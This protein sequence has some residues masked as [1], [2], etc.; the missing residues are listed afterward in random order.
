[1]CLLREMNGCAEAL[2]TARA[3]SPGLL[4]R[5]VVPAWVIPVTSKRPPSPR[6]VQLLDFVRAYT[7]ARGRPP[8][9]R[10][11]GR[12]LRI[13]ST[14]GVRDHL[15]AL[16]KKGLIEWEPN[17]ARGIRVLGRVG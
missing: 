11:I 15:L 13:R 9:Q 10:E 3:S 7:K 17:V 16:A 1:M 5:C 8:T 4:A 14:N 6:Q 12:R 2:E